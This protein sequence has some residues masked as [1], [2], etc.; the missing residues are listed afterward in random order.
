TEDMGKKNNDLSR[1]LSELGEAGAQVRAEYERQ[2]AV[3]R[4]ANS[5]LGDALH[6]AEQRAKAVEKSKIGR[7]APPA[8][9]VREFSVWV[10]PR[11]QTVK[12]HV[13]E[14]AVY[15]AVTEKRWV[16]PS[17]RQIS[18]QVY[19]AGKYKCEN[20]VVTD[21]CGQHIESLWVLASAGHYQT[22][23]TNELVTAGHWETAT[24]QVVEQEARYYDVERSE[25]VSA[26]HQE[27]RTERVEVSPG[28]WDN[29]G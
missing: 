4:K 26:G 3:E 1:R 20:V 6:Q 18:R 23:Q 22:V 25:L 14:P 21:C 7:W 27:S 17:Y 8:Y 28:H 2:L 16:E 12:Q 5:H 29:G 15:R 24:R 11:Y 19:V 10:P 9:E 13:I